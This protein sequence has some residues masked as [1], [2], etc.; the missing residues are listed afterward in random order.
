MKIL[1]ATVIG[2]TAANAG[3][4]AGLVGTILVGPW[5]GTNYPAVNVGYAMGIIAMFVSFVLALRALRSTVAVYA[6]D[7]R[8]QW[9]VHSIRAAGLLTDR[10]RTVGRY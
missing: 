9:S 1:M 3:F 4:G 2:I 5:T 6:T 10:I 8:L 7:E